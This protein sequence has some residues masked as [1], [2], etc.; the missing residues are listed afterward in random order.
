MKKNKTTRPNSSP[1]RFSAG[2][3][4]LGHRQFPGLWSALGLQMDRAFSDSRSPASLARG[5]VEASSHQPASSIRRNRRG[6]ETGSASALQPGSVLWSSGHRL[7]VGGV[8]RPSAPFAAHHQP[9][10]EP[11]G[12]DAS[13]HGALRVEGKKISETF[14]AE[15]KRRSPDGLCRSLLFARADSAFTA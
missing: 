15:C 14:R 9:H 5:P 6:G 1:G 2:R 13:P 11:G 3:I 12:T 10:F 4:G 7:G 8:G